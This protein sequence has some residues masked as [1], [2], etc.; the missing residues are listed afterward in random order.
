MNLLNSR[1][2]GPIAV[3]FA[4]AIPVLANGCSSSDN[5][6]NAVCCTDFKVGADLSQADFGVDASLKGQF[7]VFAQAGSDFGAVGTGM[8][9]DVT[10]ACYT[11]A[12]DLG[13]TA[14]QQATVDANTDPGAAAKA[15]CNLAVAQIQAT[16]GAGVSVTVTPPTFKC[17]A[18]VSAKGS[19]QAKCD[20]NGKCDIKANPPVCTG[21]TLEVT[22]D[23]GCDG[24]VTPG[25]IDC[26]GS[27]SA[28]VSGS[29]NATGGVQCKG[30]CDGTCEGN[31]DTTGATCTG[32]CKGT[33]SA[34]APGV[35]CNGQFQGKCSGMCT[36]TT[37]SVKVQCSAG[38]NLNA[39]PISCAGGKLEGGCKVD[40]K[41][42][43]NC[44]ASVNAK[45]SCDVQPLE[46]TATATGPN[47][48]AVVATLQTNVP[49]LFLAV[50]ARGAVVGQL[51]TTLSGEGTLELF[52]DP[53]SLGVKG[54]ACATQVVAA[55]SQGATDATA[56]ISAGTTLTSS[57][58]M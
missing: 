6:L 38:C 58:G 51:A 46:I 15:Q 18:S 40:A 24:S 19:C 22:C 8:L 1:F 43:A 35:A 39:T 54:L 17:E 7:E 33:C 34:T 55:I 10:T 25:G 53:S 42:D 27:C 28:T 45:A 30:K 13:A 56:S 50:K 49:K 29:C 26:Q 41:C 37:P 44:N 47:V 9:T 52:A 5:P 31:T 20:V 21:G 57:I 2:K 48:D 3:A 14:D 11:I 12:T 23:A 32:M 16:L 36:A 4:L